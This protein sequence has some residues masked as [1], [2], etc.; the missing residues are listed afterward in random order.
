MINHRL[1]LENHFQE[2]LHLIDVWINKRSG[3]TVESWCLNTSI[4]P[5]IDHYQEVLT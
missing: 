4:F 1:K 5:S 2:I 3:W